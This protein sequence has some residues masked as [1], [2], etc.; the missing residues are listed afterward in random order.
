MDQHMDSGFSFQNEI[1]FVQLSNGFVKPIRM[2][3]KVLNY[4]PRDGGFDSQSCLVSTSWESV[5]LCL[6]QSAMDNN[7]EGPSI[8]NCGCSEQTLSKIQVGQVLETTQRIAKIPTKHKFSTIFLI[9]KLSSTRWTSIFDNYSSRPSHKHLK[10]LFG[11]MAPLSPLFL[12]YYKITS[13]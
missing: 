7:K 9:R 2:V 8:Y 3:S 5:S 6:P 13:S 10:T 11:K 12:I 1:N 4:Q